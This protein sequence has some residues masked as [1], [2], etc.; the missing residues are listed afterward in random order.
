MWFRIAKRSAL[1]DGFGVT[2]GRFLVRVGPV[3][4]P[5]NAR[6]KTERERER[7]RERESP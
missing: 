1:R 2:S 3:T 4:D 5:G 6:V 7:E